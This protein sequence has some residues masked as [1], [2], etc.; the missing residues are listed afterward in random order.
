MGQSKTPTPGGEDRESR[1]RGIGV[2]KWI[3]RQPSNLS[4]K[5]PEERHHR[6]PISAGDG[7]MIKKLWI[8]SLAFLVLAGCT[9]A[10]RGVAPPDDSI[11]QFQRVAT[12]SLSEFDQMAPRPFPCDGGYYASHQGYIMNLSDWAEQSGLS[13]G[14]RIIS[15]AGVAV[16]GP[17]DR[18]RALAGV[19]VGGPVVVTVNRRGHEVKV[20]LP[21]RDNSMIWSTWR[22]MFEAVTRGDWDGCLDASVEI[23]RL[24]RRVDSFPIATRLECVRA[25]IRTLKRPDGPD[26]DRLAY[27]VAH[28][29]LR[30]SR[31]VPGET[32]RFRGFVL[33][34]AEFLRQRGFPSLGADLEV[35]LREALKAQTQAPP[36]TATPTT[37]RGT[38]FAVRPDG[39]LLTASH[40]VRDAKMI[41]ASCPGN[42]PSPATLGET[43]GNTDL[44][45]LRIG[46][47]TPTYLSL[48]EA[49]T[50]KVGDPVF[51]IGFPATSLLG[52]E[53][54]FTDG[55]VSALSGP[56]GEAT[57]VQITVPVQP[58]NSG[59]PLLNNEG[60]VVGVVTS[61]AAIRAFL[62]VT[63]TLPQNINWAV[64]S[65]YALPLFDPPAAH[66]PARDRAEAINT[67]IQATC[68]IEATQ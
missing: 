13:R 58:G 9:P 47:P 64:K 60:R 33:A 31:Y 34:T 61:S 57:L 17:E 23:P 10:L 37:S 63:G 67:A 1:T 2:W 19:P 52:S 35:Q 50:L 56:G 32:D 49:R 4:V 8:L 46:Q 28:L 6:T 15:I 27:E 20:S 42:P 48:A 40:I 5:P 25:K 11:T 18:A 38:A 54:K 53:P 26:V 44:A 3:R 7:T 45:V 59:A 29:R 65:A 68:M 39:I 66:P 21:C 51:T 30:E 12:R 24:Q 22:Q 43:A 55:S 14:D 16:T 62:T 41:T 36:P